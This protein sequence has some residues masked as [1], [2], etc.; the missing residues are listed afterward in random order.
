MNKKIF[1]SLMVIG[2]AGAVAG[3]GT[4]AYFN[5]TEAATGNSF[6]AGAVDL[7]IDWAETY[8]GG[9]VETSG[10][11]EEPQLVDNAGPVIELDDVKPGD[12]GCLTVSTHVFNNPS[13]LWM[14]MDVRDTDDPTLTEPEKEAGDNSQGPGNGELQNRVQFKVFHDNADTNC[15]LQQNQQGERKIMGLKAKRI[16]NETVLLDGDHSNEPD[17]IGWQDSS[18]TKDPFQNSET[19]FIS[20]HWAFWD[21]GNVQQTD[22]MKLDIELFAEQERNNQNPQ[23]P[24][25]S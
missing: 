13:W 3:S 5:D 19:R 14:K 20:I 25:N 15:K 11:G 12:S 17:S 21:S 23:N 6:E 1:A 8:N 18:I 2:I 22:T 16:D 9:V 4:L 7:K 10:E 24:W